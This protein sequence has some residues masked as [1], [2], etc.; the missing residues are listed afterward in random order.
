MFLQHKRQQAQS[1]NMLP[2]TFVDSPL[3][4]HSPFSAEK[5][6][7]LLHFYWLLLIALSDFMAPK[8]Q[9][10]IYYFL[11]AT[12]KHRFDN[13]SG[14]HKWKRKTW[15]P[16][17]PFTPSEPTKWEI[18]LN[19]SPTLPMRSNGEYSYWNT[20]SSIRYKNTRQNQLI[21]DM[22]AIGSEQALNMR[23]WIKRSSFQWCDDV[24][25]WSC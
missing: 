21:Y 13:S 3:L 4:V 15:M 7:I 16:V 8:T 22:T 17:W 24:C 11:L 2:N 23:Q 5:L 6:Q 19:T 20:I 18:L 1:V 9:I 10:N 25:A 12:S 14:N